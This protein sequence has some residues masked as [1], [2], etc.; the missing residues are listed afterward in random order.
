MFSRSD[1]LNFP[2][3]GCCRTQPDLH[4]TLLSARIHIVQGV[5][6]NPLSASGADK[7]RVHSGNLGEQCVNFGT[8]YHQPPKC[9]DVHRGA[10]TPAPKYKISANAYATL[11]PHREQKVDSGP[12]GALQLIQNT[13][14]WAVLPQWGQN[15][16]AAFSA[17]PQ[18]LHVP[19]GAVESTTAGL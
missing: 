2:L 1:T 10:A 18:P 8:I 6:S 14:A 3:S 11:L 9:C 13:S 7:L 15:F 19:P 16:S 17:L 12:I 4:T 5:V